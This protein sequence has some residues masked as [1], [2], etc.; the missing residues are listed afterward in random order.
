MSH[1]RSVCLLKDGKILVAIAEERLDRDKKSLGLM[2]NTG[3]KVVPFRSITYCLDSADIGIDD[4]DL[5]I[6]DQ[7]LLPV[8]VN[9]IKDIIPVKDKTKIR[10]IPHPS[11]HLAHAYSTYFCS[12]FNE[13]A[14]LVADVVGSELS[15]GIEGES[16]L[17]AKGNKIDLVFRTTYQV[18]GPYIPKDKQY[19]SLTFIYHFIT[20]VLGFTL[21]YEYFKRAD[22]P[23]EAGKTM[24]LAAYGKSVSN[25][26]SI[27]EHS[28]SGIKTAKFIDWVLINKIGEIKDEGLIPRMR[29]PSEKI[30]QFHKNLAYKAQQELEKGL[31]Y[32]ANKLFSK[33]KCKNL[34]IAGGAGLNCLANRKILDNTPFK[35]IFI[36]PAATDDGNA[37][38][39][40]MYGWHKISKRKKR[41]YMKNAYLGRKYVKEEI[42]VSLAQHN[43]LKKPLR[44]KELI[45]QVARFIADGKI[46]GW[47][48]GASEFGPRAL[49]HRSILADPRNPKMKELLNKKVKHRESFQPY[50]PSILLEFATEY[51]DLPCP[52]PFMLLVAQVKKNKYKKIPAVIHI[53][54]TVR[55]Q[56][57][58]KK[59]NGIF[60]DLLKEFY[61]I[62]KIPLVLNSSFNTKGEPIVETFSDAL[63]VFL[64]T[65]MDILVLENYLLKGEDKKRII[66][67]IKKSQKLRPVINI[68]RDNSK[69]K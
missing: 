27:V 16:G 63:R 61:R 59:D 58:T 54:G 30:T 6:V 39:C 29:L 33:T 38:G 8:N 3:E 12:P 41:F 34:C 68:I 11:H 69:M 53:D 14:I 31:I 62:A 17:Y 40:A 43:V 26:P 47:F 19:F 18:R 32:Y 49:G 4:V 44:K 24:A 48:R 28:D 23:D 10:S 65:E 51:F 25:W 55:I 50:A 20:M 60:Y 15:Q 64:N 5:L 21:P 42:L 2:R 52:S 9:T 57:V 22:Y 56:T 1:D 66:E 36:Q 67:E 46:V 13:S 45:K 7:A 37:I 35:N